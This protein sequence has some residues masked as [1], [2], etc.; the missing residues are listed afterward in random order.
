M[1]EDDGLVDDSHRPWS[2]NLFLSSRISFNLIWSTKV[3]DWIVSFMR[4]R[5]ISSV[6]WIF[7]SPVKER[8][9]EMLDFFLS[10]ELYKARRPPSLEGFHVSFQVYMSPLPGKHP[11]GA[12]FFKARILSGLWQ[13]LKKRKPL[14]LNGETLPS[15]KY[16]VKS[17]LKFSEEERDPATYVPVTLQP[18]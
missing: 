17:F 5:S 18:G 12:P 9:Y 14:K 3:R 6:W 11:P 13:M 7:M 10:S 16:F 15:M 8:L 2:I 4:K 1:R